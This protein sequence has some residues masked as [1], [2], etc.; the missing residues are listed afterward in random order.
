MSKTLLFLEKL[1][2]IEVWGNAIRADQQI[3]IIWVLSL[4]QRINEEFVQLPEGWSR[5]LPIPP[6]SGSFFKRKKIKFTFLQPLALSQPS[7]HRVPLELSVHLPQ[8]PE[9][10]RGAWTLNFIPW[11][12]KNRKLFTNNPFPS[13]FFWPNV[14]HTENFVGRVWEQQEKKEKSKFNFFFYRAG[15]VLWAEGSAGWSWMPSGALPVSAP[16]YL[17]EKKKI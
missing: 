6:N 3:Q 7:C 8:Q 17:G 10:Q 16:W 15:E 2:M 13:R 1:L 4:L 14:S 5:N 9:Q 12:E 11:I